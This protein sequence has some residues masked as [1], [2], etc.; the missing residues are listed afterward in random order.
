MNPKIN[1]PEG[2]VWGAATASYQIEGA[3]N[4]DGKSPSIWDAFSATPG[5]ILDGTT[6]DIANDHYH[7]YETDLDLMQSLNLQ[8]YRFSVAW[9]RILPQG[10]GQANAKGLAFYDRL[11]DGLLARDIKPY[12]TL[13]HWDLPLVLHEQGGWQSRDSIAWFGEYAD[14]LARHYGDRVENWMTINEPNIFAANGY[15]TGEHAPGLTDVTAYFGASHHMNC[16][17]GTATRV[18]REQVKSCRIGLV[19]HLQVIEPISEADS[20]A[21]VR[22]D[23]A[24]HRM[25]LDGSLKGIYP[26]SV[27]AMMDQCGITIEAGD[28]ELMSPPTDFVGV[29]HYTRYFVRSAPDTPEGARIDMDYQHPGSEY[30]NIGWEI[31]PDGFHQVLMRI[32]NEYDLPVI[33]TENG[34]TRVD[35]LEM[36]NGEPVVH[37]PERIDF[38]QRYLHGMKQAMDDGCEVQGYFAWTLM[39]NFEWAEG[40]TAR[41]GLIYVD[42]ETLERTPKD[43]AKWY[44]QFIRE[45]S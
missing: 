14:V 2:F 41:F 13:F 38:Y 7:R 19:T 32:K 4:Q 25:Y 17:H 35:H 36:E 10:T 44:S 6:G 23:D 27:N 12:L 30:T 26:D 37:D 3:H 18:I 34:R 22:V 9:T 24:F 15:L 45:N 43:S 8:A 20:E 21:A 1:V 16:A 28:M 33:V 31:Y 40:L 39:D 11:I 5:K 29:N 42:Y